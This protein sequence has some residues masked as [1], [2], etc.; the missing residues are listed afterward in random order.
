MT[1]PDGVD[2]SLAAVTVLDL[3]YHDVTVLAGGVR[4]WAA[5]GLQL[6]RGL[7]GVM[8][9]PDDVVPAGPERSHADMIEYLRW[10]EALGQKYAPA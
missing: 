8:D 9:P 2:A 6:E 5:A 4:A 1:S 7:T 10:E 3:G